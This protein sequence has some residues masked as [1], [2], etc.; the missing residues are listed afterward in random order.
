MKGHKFAAFQT[1]FDMV[2]EQSAVRTILSSS[3]KR[4]FFA[5]RLVQHA[6]D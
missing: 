3:L 4:L 6:K 1:N 5:D 2:C